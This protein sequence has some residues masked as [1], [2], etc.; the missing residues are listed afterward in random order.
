MCRTILAERGLPVTGTPDIPTLNRLTLKE[1]QLLPDHTHHQS[2]GTELMKRLS[3]NLATVTQTLAELRGLY[4]TA[5]RRTGTPWR[6]SPC[7]PKIGS[8]ES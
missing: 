6:L 4:G 8:D 2:K 1:L 3:S 5:T 7:G